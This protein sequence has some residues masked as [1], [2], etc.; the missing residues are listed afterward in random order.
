MQSILAMMNGNH[1]IPSSLVPFNHMVQNP[2]NMQNSHN[3]DNFMKIPFYPPNMNANQ[4]STN[5][6]PLQN[7]HLFQQNQPIIANIN[8]NITSSELKIPQREN[9]VDISV[10][11]DD[12]SKE[13]ILQLLNENCLLI[14]KINDS[15]HKNAMKLMN[16]L[17]ITCSLK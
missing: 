11:Q 16:S 15:S 3:L 6:F 17:E 2:Y 5:P 9:S 7:L 14:E 10:N 1:A 12:Q 13:K 4:F 8:N